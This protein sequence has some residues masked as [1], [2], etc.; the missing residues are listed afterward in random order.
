AAQTPRDLL[1]RYSLPGTHR[2]RPP[3]RLHGVVDPELSLSAGHTDQGVCSEREACVEGRHLEDRIALIVADE[4]VRDPGGVLVQCTVG[5]QTVAG[6]PRTT[7]VGD[8]GHRGELDVEEAG[9]D[10]TSAV[11]RLPARARNSSSPIA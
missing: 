7:E 8:R 1:D 6:T 10:V 4:D 11:I 2:D 9:H 5:R 3:A